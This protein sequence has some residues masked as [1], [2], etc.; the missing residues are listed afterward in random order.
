MT[1]AA[2]P[3]AYSAKPVASVGLH[4]NKASALSAFNWRDQAST[5]GAWLMRGLN[6]A[7]PVGTPPP[8]LPGSDKNRTTSIATPEKVK[9]RVRSLM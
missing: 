2:L 8:L 6:P 4:T 1:K 5:N 9:Q 3:K 7:K